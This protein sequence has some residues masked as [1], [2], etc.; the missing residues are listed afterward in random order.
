MG[1]GG[2]VV[3]VAVVVVVGPLNRFPA[4]SQSVLNL[5]NAVEVASPRS[6]KEM[7]GVH[8][9]SGIVAFTQGSFDQHCCREARRF[10]ATK[11][12]EARAAFASSQGNPA[13][14]KNYESRT[15]V[16][17]GANSGFRR[18]ISPGAPRALSGSGV[19]SLPMVPYR[20]HVASDVWLTRG[21]G[22]TEG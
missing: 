19:S 6:P 20:A 18:R 22:R 14:P 15:Q 8:F 12:A 11:E 17:C 7:R 5:C 3:A 4:R 13:G 10:S 16:R 9:H 21:G 1:W 2:V